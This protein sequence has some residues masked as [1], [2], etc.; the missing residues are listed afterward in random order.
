M[1]LADKIRACGI[2]VVP[3][4]FASPVY[5]AA[6]EGIVLEDHSG[7]PVAH[8]EVCVSRLLAPP[9][10]AYLETDAEGRFRAPDVPP[11]E[12]RITVSKPNYLDATVDVRL[13]GDDSSSSFCALRLIRRGAVSGRVTDAQGQPVSGATVLALPRPPGA[14]PLRRILSSGSFANVDG[15]GEYRIY[16]LPPG[17]YAIAASYGASPQALGATGRRL[18]SES[19]GSGYLFYPNNAQPEHLVVAGGEEYRN[20]DFQI[21]PATLYSVSGRVETPDAGMRVWLALT[22]VDQPGL[23][24]AVAQTEPGG[25]FR[26]SGVPPG[27]YHLFASGPVIGRSGRGAML[28]AAPVSARTV[29]DVGGQDRDDIMISAAPGRPASFALRPADSRAS[30][31]PLTAQIVLSPLEDWGANL[32]R[33]VSVT[34]PLPVTIPGLAPTSFSFPASWWTIMRFASRVS[35]APCTSVTYCTTLP[36]CYIGRYGPEALSAICRSASLSAVTEVF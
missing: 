15:R 4:L 27:S 20:V 29:V 14:M 7:K 31:C 23:A 1:G 16:N 30:G 26:F 5:V 33:R 32:E 18:T 6:L 17:E 25:A 13:S 21:S 35:T 36:V 12:Y 8:A 22:P 3:V 19:L 34:M 11:G 24:I 10:T 28:G 2:S 9:S